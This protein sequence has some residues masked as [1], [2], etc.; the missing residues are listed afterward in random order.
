M[1]DLAGGMQVAKPQPEINALEAPSNLQDILAGLLV[2]CVGMATLAVFFLTRAE[3]RALDTATTQYTQLQAEV[4]SGP[5]KEVANTA[6]HIADAI[7]ILDATKMTSVPWSVLLKDLQ[8]TTSP[9]VTLRSLTLDQEQTLKIEGE[10]ASYDVL[11]KYLAT[12]RASS[13]LT[14]AELISANLG[15]GG[16][17]PTIHFVTSMRVKTDALSASGRKAGQS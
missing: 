8:V 7:T 4:T 10:A 2:V 13:A 3:N 6:R 9:G 12:L 5:L 17:Q 16:N 15:Q 1:L 11:A 14:Q